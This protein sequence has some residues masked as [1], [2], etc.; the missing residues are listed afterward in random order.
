MSLLS[1]SLSI[2]AAASLPGVNFLYANQATKKSCDKGISLS[3]HVT[4]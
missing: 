1:V 4:L 3:G 2:P